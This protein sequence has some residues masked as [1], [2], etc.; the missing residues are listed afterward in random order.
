MKKT[1]FFAVLA[2]LCLFF[3]LPAQEISPRKPTTVTGRVTDERG[4]PLPSATVRYGPDQQI[5]YTDQEGRFSLRLSGRTEL[6]VSYTGYQRLTITADPAKPALPDIRMQPAKLEIQQVI[7]STGYQNIAR[8]RATG[9]F[10]HLDSAV[11]NR[12][13]GP[14]VLSRLEGV[15]PGLLFNRN[16]STAAGNTADLSIRGHST[17][18]SNDQ[19]LVVIDNFPY[20]GDLN[21]INPN[22]VASIT[23]LKDAAAASIWGVRSG[24]GVIVITT[25][26]GRAGQPTA[27]EFNANLTSGD[28]PNLYYDPNY[29]NAGEFIGLEQNLFKTGYYDGALKTGYQVV[30]PVVALLNKARSGAISQTDADQQIAA[31][32]GYDIRRDESEYL[33]RRSFSQQYN[34]NFRGGGPN[35]D[36][37]F[38]AG[39]DQNNAALRGNTNDRLTINSNYNFSPFKNLKLS[40]GINYIKNTAA[41][42]ST[43]SDL[44]SIRGKSMIYPYARLADDAGNPLATVKDFSQAFVDNPGN[45]GFLD[46][47]YRALDELHNSNHHSGSIDTRLNFGLNYRFFTHFT[48]DIKYQYERA[49]S[50]DRTIYSQDSYYARNLINQYAQTTADGSLSF[51]VPLGGIRMDGSSALASHRIRGQ[52]NYSGRVGKGGQLNAIAGTEWSGENTES[53]SETPAY[54]YNPATG[55][56]SG[57]VNYADYFG[58]NPRQLGSAQIPNGQFFGKRTDNF[59]SYFG[60]AAYSF[61]GR[62]TVS[63]SGRIDRSNLFGVHANQKAVPLYSA[64]FTWNIAEEKFYHV[65]WLEQLRLRG[66]F[67]YNGN[68]NKSATAVTTIRQQSNSYF[69][70]LPYAVIANP[71]NPDL[72]W[73]K[74]RMINLG[75]DFG[76]K[77]Q[78]ITGT[79]EFYFKKGVN[80]FGNAS[81][82][83]ST[84][85]LTFF[86]NTAETKGHGAD[87]TINSRNIQTGAFSWQT[88]FQ[89]SYAIDKVTQYNAQLRT[90]A[91]LQQGAGNSGTITPLVGQPLFGIYSF[92]SGPL[93]HETGDPQGYLNGALST[94]YA[95]VI[96]GT[97]VKDLHYNGPSRPTSFGSL[98]NTF[99]YKQLSLSFNLIYKLGYYIRRSSVQYGSLYSNWLGNQDYTRRW[100][101][102]DDEARTLIP[103]MPK[104]P[105][106]P[107][108][109]LFYT[110]SD[111]LVDKGD[112]I[113]LKDI[114][115]SYDLTKVFGPKGPFS[116]INVYAYV[117]NVAILWRANPDHLD[118]DVFTTPGGGTTALPLPRTFAVGLKTNLK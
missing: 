37:Y 4:K 51:P 90:L 72:R 77:N 105:V 82:A 102:P 43:L 28:K 46:W 19:P 35:S 55:A 20:D 30:S 73:E 7:V 96:A 63:A 92:R 68:I 31:M 101:Q 66:T 16:T 107:N 61:L 79:V 100:Q 81:V 38:S 111:A 14:D 11:I 67:G 94:D 41:L 91:F 26:K 98:W 2:T 47:N 117:N 84:G 6:T 10:V 112:H 24:N 56:F 21:N 17:L 44:N 78:A 33:L 40:A 50:T 71:G 18:F 83:P 57:S 45:T 116:H 113:R 59:I 75:L 70:G 5:T 22:D 118:P 87:V 25:K 23:I 42:N 85:F 54:G 52:L 13:T 109:D 93:T 29:L 39:Y 114:N 99:S 106:N 49:E 62:Y 27:I 95:A 9:S 53:T 36:Y 103:S 58:L 60:N 108:R 69:S 32:K 110:F 1:I 115:I 12:R 74:D 97:T 3:K 76:L 89:Y 34:L 15:V 104:T 86:G 48:A 65:D 64:G 80:L 88:N 8:E